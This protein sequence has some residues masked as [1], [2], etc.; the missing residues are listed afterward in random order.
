MRWGGVERDV[1][2]GDGAWQQSEREYLWQQ[3]VRGS[4]M[5]LVGRL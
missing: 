3:E 1:I 2:I 4:E 5:M